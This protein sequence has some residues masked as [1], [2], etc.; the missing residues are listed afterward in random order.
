VEKHVKVPEKAGPDAPQSA[1]FDRRPWLKQ[2]Y[3]DESQYIL[4][5]KGRQ[6]E[7]SEWVVNW[8][9]YHALKDPGKYVYATASRE[10]ADI[11]SRD[12]WQKQLLRSPDLMAMVRTKAVRETVLNKSEVYFMSAYE[13]T[14]ALRSIDADAVV[15]DEFQSYRVNAIP[16]AQAG[17]SHSRFKRMI[18][19][20]TPVLTGSGFSNQW[21]MTDMKEWDTTEK[22]WK[23]TNPK[24]DGLWSGYHISQEFA[25]GI[26]I[27]PEEFEFKRKHAESRQAFEN[28]VLGHFYAGLGRPTDRV[29]METLFSPMLTKGTYTQGETLIAGV[30]W[31]IT[32]SNTVFV[33]IRPRL[34]QAPDIYTL[35]V[36][37]IERIDETDLTKQVYRVAE[38]LRQFPVTLCV[39]DE[40]SG[41][42]QNQ[43]LFKQFQNKILKIQ[44]TTGSLAQPLRIEPTQYGAMIHANRTYAIDTTMDYITNPARFRFYYEPDERFKD[45]IIKDI[46]A[47]YPE[48]TTTSEK[49]IWKHNEDTTDDV[50]LA[51]TNA[52]MGFQIT[53]GAVI[54]DNA[55]D[56][57]S[58]A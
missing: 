7:A 55:N 37:Y 27:T 50:L 17:I 31:G 3:H 6:M 12:R 21:E 39:C 23:A 36:V 11:F 38:L 33:L 48:L 18:V 47:E 22:I 58:W 56:W 34:Y 43:M 49:K 15:L 45:F 2:L 52:I 9:F 20:G 5:E 1:W 53:K 54:P 29:Y 14:E 57:L 41:Q 24:W 30:D 51:L 25:V 10:K 40:G 44:M 42:M 16:I 35:D 46:L 28:E 32:Q 8:L 4:L 13:D 19:V 26:W